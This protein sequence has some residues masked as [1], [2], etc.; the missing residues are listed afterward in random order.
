M[1]KAYLVNHTHWDREWYF[2]TQDAQVLSDQLFTQVLDELESHPEANFTLDGQMSIIDE[3]VEIH[4]E[5]K[6]RIHDL[7]ERGQLFIGPWYTQT[8][9]NIP[10]AE[11][12]LRNLVIGINDARKYY[13]RAMMLGYLPD[14]FGFNANLP[15]ILNQVGI[16][17]FLSWRGTNFKRQAGSVYFKWRALGNS[18]VFAA[19]FPLGY[20]T[21]QIDLASK[22]NLKD[23]VKNRLDKGIEF[24]A[25][26]G[27][28]DEVL[29]PSGIDQMNIVHN[30]S[31]TVKKI[32]QY[33]KNDVQIST[34]PEFMK[35]LRSKKLNTYQGELR[36]PTYSRVHR[37][38]ASV[39]SRNKRKNFKLEQDILRRVEPL[40]LIAKKS[41]I[42]VSNGLLI[43]LW[44]QLF[45]SQP[46]DTLGGSVTDN[47]AVDIDHRFKQAF[48]IADGL[49]NYIKKRIA[50]RLNLTDKD[51]IV[52]NTDPY[53]FDGYKL[54]TF[55]SASKKIK[56]PDKYEATL[57]KEKYTPTRPNIMQL[58]PNG[59]EFKDEPGYYKLYVLIKLR[60]NGLGYKVIHFED[61][62]QEL[63]S[64]QELDNN[65]IANDQLTVVYQDGKFTL[66]DK[67][68]EYYDVISVYD[69]ANDGD[70]YDFSPLRKDHEIRLNWNGK[71]TKKETSTYKELILEGKWLLPY[72]LDDRL[73][74]DGQKKEVPFKL[75]VSLTNGEKVLSCRLHINNTVL[76]HRL[77]LR[78][79]SRMQTEYA[80][81]QIQGGFRKTK[82]EPIDDNWNDEFVEK[83]VNIYIFDRAVGQNDGKNGLYFF[84]K[85]E[86]E[87]ELVDDSIYVTLMATTGQLGKSNLL[88]RPG[89]AS[90]DTTSV[91][92]VMTPTPMAEE[93]GNNDFEFG[94]TPF[95]GEEL[96]E[97]NIA[98]RLD[99]WLSP[100][101][102]YQIQKY[103]LFVNRLDNKIWDIE[104]PDNLPKITDEESYLDLNLLD[105]IEVSALYPAYTIKDTMVLRLSNMT[106][107]T[108]DL[109][110]LKKKGYIKTNALEEVDR[111]DYK[112]G[113]YDMN[114]FIRKM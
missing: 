17:D 107:E 37:T 29:I 93:L 76:A 65:S 24:E 74:E 71:L 45:D 39:R 85:G 63:T 57:V 18:V 55:M 1:V 66:R 21:G 100:N 3:Y 64:L 49:E 91:G 68:Q 67:N 79:R 95:T 106:S 16:H 9:A 15:M 23:F 77:R 19:N 103:N 31:D 113:P 51:V 11:S 94:I 52:F 69:Q 104:F 82:N 10:A 6:E 34:Y 12:L 42:Q 47:V 62:D 81:T 36:Y 105:G 110:F 102:S 54:I 88:W 35:R 30:I 2:T 38:I 84:G 87:Y 111:S 78:M 28:N 32:N 60:M 90:G 20:Y 26:N 46:H 101:V 43:K 56:F 27:N 86:K 44:K 109:S 14:T 112:V 80:H 25:K 98:T 97:K 108:I 75:T 72:S 70:T 40:M 58:T 96:S 73:K 83:P 4:P 8:D 33:S 92:H 99:K 89:R 13:G 59:F 7:V 48:E 114:T 22:K 5:A 41:S 53:D 61:A 50:Q